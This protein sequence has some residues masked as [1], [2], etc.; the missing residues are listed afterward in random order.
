MR[1]VVDHPARYDP[2]RLGQ[3]RRTRGR[4]AQEEDEEQNALS[5][6]AEADEQTVLPTATEKSALADLF[7]LEC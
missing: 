7:Q 5:Y 1:P 3:C 4:K 2:G 6:A